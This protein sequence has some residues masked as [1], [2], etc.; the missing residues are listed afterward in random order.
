[1]K[2]LKRKVAA[3]ACAAVSVVCSAQAVTAFAAAKQTYCQQYQREVLK[4]PMSDALRYWANKYPSKTRWSNSVKSGQTIG[5]GYRYDNS[6]NNASDVTLYNS[7]AFARQL[8]LDYFETNIYIRMGTEKTFTPKIGDQITY[9][10]GSR[11]QTIFLTDT[12]TYAQCSE[13][14]YTMIT[15][16]N[17]C[18][19]SNGVLVLNGKAYSIKYVERPVKVGD[20]NGDTVIDSKD[21]TAMNFYLNN[22]WTT[23]DYN[24][25]IA[26]CDIDKNG[27]VNMTDYN[28]L[29]NNTDSTNKILKNKGYVASLW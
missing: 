29:K 11:L 6:V 20:A 1:M 9:V 21:L 24:F 10:N 13:D 14:R 17:K 12:N 27:V 26:A 15:Y 8:A 4:T 18:S 3:I 7:A 23:Y 5:F 19:F 28:Y 16:G 2:A 25:F 22:K